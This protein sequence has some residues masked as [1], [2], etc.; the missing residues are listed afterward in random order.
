MHPKFRQIP[1]KPRNPLPVRLEA[2]E[3]E[4]DFRRKYHPDGT[5]KSQT[6][7][8]TRYCNVMPGVNDA[9]KPYPA[10]IHDPKPKGGN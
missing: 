8:K 4:H 6:N 1:H 2:P 7:C 9:G 5:L 10:T 3:H